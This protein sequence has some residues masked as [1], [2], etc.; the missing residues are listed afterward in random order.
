MMKNLLPFFII[1]TLIVLGC[2][3]KNEPDSVHNVSIGKIIYKPDSLVLYELTSPY[4]KEKKSSDIEWRG[5]DSYSC[6]Y[7]SIDGL[8]ISMNF[9]EM[10]GET[11]FINYRNDTVKTNLRS[12]GC[13]SHESFRYETVKQVLR[14]NTSNVSEA[15]SII[16]YIDYVGIQDIEHKIKDWESHGGNSNW[17]IG[18]KPNT[19]KVNG[20]FKLKIFDDDFEYSEEYDRSIIFR[21]KQLIADIKK[22]KKGNLDSLN[23]SRLNIDTLPRELFDLKS[24]RILNLEG[25]K[26]IDVDFKEL[27]SLPNLNK[28]YLGWNGFK[29]F[30]KNLASNKNLTC[31]DLMGNPIEKIPIKD[32]LKSNVKYL[33][34]S[35][36]NVKEEELKILA[37]KMQIVL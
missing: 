11:F 33:N 12:W 2:T 22:I 29:E 23:C 24:I 31:I 6:Y 28:L 4:Q 35:G 17:L 5:I 15:D 13:T 19:A 37:S 25:N 10:N 14:L 3:Q 21:R 30:P 18:M 1:I 32:L 16:G 34:L 7:D 26:I 36:S 9:G 27:S 20:Y 8:K